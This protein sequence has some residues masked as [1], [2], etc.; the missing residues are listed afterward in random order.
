MFSKNIEV[1][2]FYPLWENKES[3]S[4]EVESLYNSFRDS[5]L[6]PYKKVKKKPTI[7]GDISKLIERL[8]TPI[9]NV[10]DA[11]CVI[12]FYFF[13]EYGNI[14]LDIFRFDRKFM[15]IHSCQK[16]EINVNSKNN[17]YHDVAKLLNDKTYLYY[18]SDD[19]KNLIFQYLL[20]YQ[21]EYYS[22]HVYSV[23]LD[24]A[25]LSLIDFDREMKVNGKIKGKDVFNEI[26]KTLSL[27]PTAFHKAGGY[28]I[29]D[30]L[31]GKY[32]ND[33]KLHKYNIKYRIFFSEHPILYGYI[34]AAEAYKVYNSTPTNSSRKVE[35]RKT[36][37]NR[38]Y[39][40]L[41]SIDKGKVS[42][43]EINFFLQNGRD[44]HEIRNEFVIRADQIL[45]CDQNKEYAEQAVKEGL[46][47]KAIFH[48]YNMVKFCGGLENYDELKKLFSGREGIYNNLIEKANKEKENGNYQSAMKLLLQAE[49]T[50]PHMPSNKNKISEVENLIIESNK[51]LP[52]SEQFEKNTELKIQVLE[53]QLS[54]MIYNTYK[55][56]VIDRSISIT[57]NGQTI[58]IKF[59]PENSGLNMAAEVSYYPVGKFTY[60]MEEIEN[61]LIVTAVHS[62]SEFFSTTNENGVVSR[63][64]TELIL[65]GSA[66]LTQ[67]K[68]AVATSSEY[69]TLETMVK[70]C[71]TGDEPK[72]LK[73]LRKSTA[74]DE[75]KNLALAYLRAYHKQQRILSK[76]GGEIS[77]SS[78]CAK[79]IEGSTKNRSV[80]IIL[81]VTLNK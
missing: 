18:R 81:Q 10:D 68:G 31:E 44:V 62:I 34:K 52:P 43:N 50:L 7:I 48:Y 32:P 49:K 80:L 21:A 42:Q 29:I 78:L 4:W 56:K 63:P 55:Y 15:T 2:G 77:N 27:K 75:E 1:Y 8:E 79:V 54:N 76:C 40:F 24:S 72:S 41:D 16:V 37:E 33:E 30:I 28:G 45:K 35:H 73:E 23:G 71:N 9:K 17:N 53:N 19:R 58:T 64:Y 51:T 11:T 65:N 20:P 26:E 25:K 57:R 46:V 14:V 5:L 69:A 22:K 13:D 47:D 12:G 59:T 3:Q 67:F 39:E 66:D 74:S 61:N 6:N 38:L 36:F 70:P 60:D